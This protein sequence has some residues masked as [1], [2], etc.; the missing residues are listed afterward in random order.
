MKLLYKCIYKMELLFFCD[1]HRMCF[2][3]ILILYM[4]WQYSEI[5]F[6]YC[7]WNSTCIEYELQYRNTYISGIVIEITLKWIVSN[8]IMQVV[9]EILGLIKERS[10]NQWYETPWI[11]VTV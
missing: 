6:L 4:K 5:N 9:N 11:N 3:L 2:K 7:R 1:A 10:E 8:A